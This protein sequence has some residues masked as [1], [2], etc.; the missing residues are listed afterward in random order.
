MKR[1]HTAYPINATTLPDSSLTACSGS[2][3]SGYEIE[4]SRNH[5]PEQEDQ[6]K[7]H[8]SVF[9]QGKGQKMF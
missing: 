1:K 6:H 9:K 5:G 3:T 8:F 2:V 7:N 4:D